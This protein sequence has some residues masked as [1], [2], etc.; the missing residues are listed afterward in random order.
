MATQQQIMGFQNMARYIGEHVKIIA[1]DPEEKAR[2]A[3]YGKDIGVLMN[4]VNAYG[5]R[6]KE[7]QQA[8]A[9][10]GGGEP[11][12]AQEAAAK[13]QALQIMTK[14]KV[15]SQDMLAAGK[16]DRTHKKWLADQERKAQ[17][18][19]AEIAN[20]LAQPKIE[21]AAADIKTAAEI[22]RD[23]AKAKAEPEKPTKKDTE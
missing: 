12:A 11:G 2:V 4:T 10:Q 20:R 13:A 5:E 21:A 9:Q 14:A 23:D 16:E 8:Q 22:R 17:A 15:E 3:Q 7:Q 18:H 1:Q 19:Q 6:L